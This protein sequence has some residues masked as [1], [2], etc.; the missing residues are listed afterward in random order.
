MVVEP[1]GAA[2]R[3]GRYTLFDEIA[4]GGMG[5]IHLGVA[6]A[7]AAF[8]RVVAIKRLNPL[9]AKEPEFRRM[10]LDEAR[11]ASRVRHPNVVP[12]F[13]AIEAG[14]EVLI[15]MEYVP[16]ESFSRLLTESRDAGRA[17]HAEVV[18]AVISGALYGLHAAHE[19]VDEAGNALG[20][21]HRDVSPQ[22]VLVG[23]DG[24]A[25]VI[26]FGVAKAAGRLQTTGHG[27]LKGKLAYMSPERLRGEPC[28]RRV[29][30]YAAGVVLWEALTGRR[31]FLGDD[32]VD[33]MR[34]A[35][36]A[37]VDPPTTLRTDLPRGLDAVTLRALAR[38]PADRFSSAREMAAELLRACPAAAPHE[39]S[40]WVEACSHEK[41]AI[42]ATR[43]AELESGLREGRSAGSLAATPVPPP[44]ISEAASQISTVSLS[45]GDAGA[46]SRAQPRRRRAWGAVLGLVGV[47]AL[48]VAAA[49]HARSPAQA[50]L[51]AGAVPPLP[52]A[53]SPSPSPAP[54]PS[55]SS[56]SEPLPSAASSA[57]TPGPRPASR[58]AVTA[59]PPRPNPPRAAASSSPSPDCSP[60]Y[61]RAEDG[62]KVWK[63]DCFGR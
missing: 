43:V 61:V 21:V 36:T 9:C 53:S 16:G 60:P 30:V 15:V 5:T 49:E 47:G 37:H 52:T 50:P 24:I 39:V 18:S 11:L 51:A 29:D 48:G 55:D 28:D 57:T 33:T 56:T 2:Y 40:E 31:L 20:L 58:R 54:T 7:E 14:G 27:R 22:N 4:S 17:V 63:R 45:R 23:V 35:M 32:E 42:A 38:E 62:T 12:T 41:L 3:V 13:D 8:S 6:R 10:F 59:S 19:T 26:D 34:K 44:A 1:G 25:R 46:D